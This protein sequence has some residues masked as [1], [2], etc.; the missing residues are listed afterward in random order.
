MG[1]KLPAEL[2][3]KLPEESHTGL[4][5]DFSDIDSVVDSDG[6]KERVSA[7]KDLDT[8]EKISVANKHQTD[9]IWPEVKLVEW[10]SFSGKTLKLL[11][12]N[13]K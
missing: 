12:Q 11:N 9:F 3:E 13:S 7:P 4:S 10:S 8:L 1:S 5:I 2:P 6:N